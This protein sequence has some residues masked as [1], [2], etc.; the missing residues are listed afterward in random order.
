[1]NHYNKHIFANKNVYYC[2]IKIHA[3]GFDELLES[4]FC[5]L[6]VV[7]VCVLVAQPYPTLCYPMPGFSGYGIFQAR[8]LEWV[9]FPSRGYF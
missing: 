2:N 3:S 8:I 4:I 7:C 9:A 1:M 5:L 6:L